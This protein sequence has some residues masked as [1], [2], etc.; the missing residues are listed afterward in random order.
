MVSLPKTSS[1]TVFPSIE[2]ELCIREALANQANDQALLRPGRAMTAVPIAPRSWEPE[3]DSLVAVEVIC[4]IE[5]LLGINLPVT[6]SPRGGYDS[7]DAC[8]NDLLS[9]AR[10]TWKQVT[11]EN[12]INEQ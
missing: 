4:A 8:V 9:Q 10:A 2:V 3:I 7:V 12:Q 6:F 5:E 11:K 1:D